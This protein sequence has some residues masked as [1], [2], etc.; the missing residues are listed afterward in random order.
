MKH[1]KQI[2][3]AITTAAAVVKV[4][5]KKKNK[6]KTN[7]WVNTTTNELLEYARKRIK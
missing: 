4:V 6:Q 7:D 3:L 1:L 2:A 5:P